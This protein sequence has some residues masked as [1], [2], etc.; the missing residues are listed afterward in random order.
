MRVFVAVVHSAFG[1]EEHTRPK[2]ITAH[3]EDFWTHDTWKNE[4]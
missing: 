2:V 3:R 4:V 1:L